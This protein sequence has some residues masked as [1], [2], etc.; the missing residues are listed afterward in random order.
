MDTLK[1]QKNTIPFNYSSPV[2]NELQ[3]IEQ[4]VKSGHISGN[5]VY[6]QR[7]QLFFESK[8]GFTT[9]L[10]TSSCTDALELASILCNLKADDEVI[11]PSYTFVSTANPFLLRGAKIV[12]ADSEKNSPNINA[13]SLESLITNKTRVIVPVHYAGVAC[14]MKKILSIAS[15]YDLLVVE[16]AAHAIDSFFDGK[17]LGSLGHMATFSFHESKNITCGE[18]GLL[19]INDKSF[20]NRAEIIWEKGTNRSAFFKGEVDKYGW[21]DVGSSFLSSDISA[22]FLYAQLENIE[23]IQ[24]KRKTIWRYY[25]ASLK[26][27]FEKNKIQLQVI[28]AYATENGHLFYLICKDTME[29]TSLIAFLKNRGI[30]ATFHYLSLH[31]SP[32]Y[33]SK[34]KGPPLLNS[35]H[36]T[37]CLLRL[38][39][40]FSLTLEQVKFVVDSIYDFFGIKNESL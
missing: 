32:Y 13:D 30:H 22:A 16:D 33:Q 36:Y 38:P 7:C 2:G 37:D 12:F 25:H 21:V 8:Y 26:P 35:D 27:L 19:V 31:K 20:T 40:Y 3:Y 17:P 39:L 29:R 34:Y 15:K 11:M 1:K 9:T 6:T 5:G 23:L 14:D 28:P 10:L 4:A 18:G 24:E